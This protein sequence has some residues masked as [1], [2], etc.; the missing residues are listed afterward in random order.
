MADEVVPVTLK[1]R[2]TRQDVAWA[3]DEHMRPDSTLEGLAKLP[4]HF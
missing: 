2:K 3:Q 4:P 1:G